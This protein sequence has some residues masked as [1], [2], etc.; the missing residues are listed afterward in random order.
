MNSVY[1]M[2]ERMAEAVL[3]YSGLSRA[4]AREVIA[5]ASPREGGRV[6]SGLL[7]AALLSRLGRAVGRGASVAGVAEDVSRGRHLA[8][9]SLALLTLKAFPA[10]H[11]LEGVVEAGLEGLDGFEDCLWDLDPEAPLDPDA[12]ALAGRY[13]ALLRRAVA[14]G[15]LGV[16]SDSVRSLQGVREAAERARAAGWD[17][18]I[19]NIYSGQ[20]FDRLIPLSSDGHYLM[21]YMYLYGPGGAAASPRHSKSALVTG[22]FR[23]NVE[24]KGLADLGVD[25]GRAAAGLEGIEFRYIFPDRVP[26]CRVL[27]ER[28]RSRGLDR[29]LLAELVSVKPPLRLEYYSHDPRRD[30]VDA[31]VYAASNATQYGVP[32]QLLVADSRSRVDEWDIGALRSLLESQARRV[33]PYS[34]YIRDFATRLR[35]M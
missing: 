27:E 2:E 13:A 32:P 10:D 8:V 19:Y 25:P 4:T 33:M 17:E 29:R 21:A 18:V 15:A 35:Y 11:R 3:A 12:Y 22:V 6:N 16:D 24:S 14:S 28:A 34:T 30:V 31:K 20:V 5:E 1:D 7:A 9:T 26:P 23:R